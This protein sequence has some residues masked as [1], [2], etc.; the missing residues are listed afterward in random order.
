MSDRSGFDPFASFSGLKGSPLTALSEM[1]SPQSSVTALREFLKTWPDLVETTPPPIA[2]CEDT[3]LPGADGEIT[4]RVYT[5]H[6]V[7]DEPGPSLVYFHGGGFM[8]GSLDTHDPM[9]RRLCAVSGVRVVS[10]DYR[11][12]PEHPFPAGFEDARVSLQA[13]LSGALADYGVDRARLAVGGDSAG[14]NFAASLA[15][16]FKDQLVFQMLLYPVLQLVQVEKDKPR[17][18]EGPLLSSMLLKEIVSGYVGEADPMDPA[19]SPLMAEDLT[20]LP[21]SYFMAA[22]MDPLL[23]EGEAYCA[24]LA[25]SGV[26]VERRVFKAAPH[27]FLNFTRVMPVAV[28]AIEEAGHALGRALD[29]A[30]D[31]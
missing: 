31:D 21:A 8:V 6:G 19:I 15:R 9:L 26:S 13:I 22:E 1:F 4:A 3:L 16:E 30:L 18:Q 5:P 28:K 11:L 2:G 7:Q 24:K 23:E 20:G 17:W 27:G 25:A 10:I 29:R 12:A 14:G